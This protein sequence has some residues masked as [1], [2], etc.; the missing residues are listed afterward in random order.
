MYRI[1]EEEIQAV[2]RVIESRKLFKINDGGQECMN[3][4]EELKAKFGTKYALLMTAGK[5]ALMSGLIGMG[6]GPGDEVIVP[7]YTYIA[8][9]IAVTAVGA[10]P[11][12]AEVDDSL[13]LCPEDFVRKISPHTKAVIPVHIMG[14]P[15]D[16]T[17]IMEIS[18]KYGIMVLEDA[19]QSD[20]GSYKDK[21][22]GT[23]GD[24]GAYSFNYF[25]IITSGEGGVLVTDNRQLYERA[26]IYHDSSAIAFFGNQLE[27]I[28]EPQF[29]GVQFRSNEITGA[30]LR[31]QLKRLDGILFDLRKNKKYLMDN[32][33]GRYNFIRS[34]DIEGDCGTT[35]P[36]FFNT[37]DEAVAFQNYAG[38]KGYGTTRP[39]DTGKHVYSNWTPIMEKRGAFHPKFDPF[40]FEENQ[41]LQ[42]DYSPDMCKQTLDLLARTVYVGID[43][44]WSEE[45][46]E[47]IVSKLK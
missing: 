25:K 33:S 37:I 21:R 41:G 44:D 19:C 2:R 26:L 35:L 6:I 39:I 24:A 9:A 23:I 18:K 16:M 46:L 29:C 8:T 15:S 3:F 14:F 20:G 27:G 40:K 45:T 36:F 10:V 28:A 43:P 22:L 11:V 38:E 12:I 4:E 31:E 47:N 1:G 13:T 17:K 5:A 30:I 32:L 42:T 7:A 34:N